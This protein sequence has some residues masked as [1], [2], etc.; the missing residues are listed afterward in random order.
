[1]NLLDVL[2]STAIFTTAV[3]PMLY[4]AATG[5]RL[6]RVTP[7]AAD[8]HQRARVVSDTLQRA[9]GMAGASPLH[10]SLP[11]GLSALVPAIVPARTGLRS[12]DPVLAAFADRLSVIAVPEGATASVLAFSMVG[13]SDRLRLDPSARGCSRSGVC[14]FTD[15]M[16]ALV[17]DPR[18]VGFGYDLFTVTSAATELAHDAPNPAFSKAYEVGAVVVPIIQRVFSFDR[19]NHRIMLYDGYQSELPL[20]D[21]VVDLEFAYFGADGVAGVQPVTLAQLSDGPVTGVG[22]T[23][24]DRDLLRLRFVRV[25]V[26]LGSSDTAPEYQMTFDVKLRN[27]VGQ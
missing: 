14:G 16:R 2:I 20:L 17:L 7:D 15:G 6:A 19:V 3:V 11:D 4:L 25:T 22:A 26:R 24:F 8:V 13:L 1:M 18:G 23:A 9:I 21:N 5:Q 10:H 12:P 27:L